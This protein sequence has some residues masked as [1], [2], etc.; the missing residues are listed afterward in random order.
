MKKLI[1]AV[2]VSLIIGFMLL[3]N[4]PLNDIV[5]F[6]I[7]GS[8]PGTNLALGFWPTIGIAAL[9]LF[10]VKKYFNHL[11]DELLQQ[12]AKQITE[13]TAKSEFKETYGTKDSASKKAIFAHAEFDNNF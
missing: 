8:I 4:D 6:L 13:E 1:L 12:T 5:N 7:A 2:L 11:N 3:S 9:L 10:G